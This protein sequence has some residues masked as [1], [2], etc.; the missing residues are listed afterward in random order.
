MKSDAVRLTDLAHGGGCG[1]KIA[2]S[3]L[4]EMLAKLPRQF[5]DPALIVGLESGD[6]AAV[7]QI[8]DQQAVV[9]T[10][11]FFMPIVDDPFEFG[12]IAANNALSDVYA[13]GG[14]P[15][16]ALAI[17]GMPVNK[18][19][20]ETIQEILA[21]GATVCEAAGVSLAGGH[22]IDTPEPIYGLAAIGLVSPIAVKRNDEARAND[23]LILGKALGVGIM[24]A[25]L[26]KGEL[27]SPGYKEML[28]VTTQLNSIGPDLAALPGVHALTDV[29]GFGLLGHL[30]EVCR[31]SGLGAT[32]DAARV[33]LV[34]VARDLAQAGHNSGAAGRNWAS[35]GDDVVLPGDFPE[36]HHNL[37]CDPQ[38]SGGLLV[39]CD[40]A[41]ADQ[42]LE[43][44]HRQGYGDAAVIGEMSDGPSKVQVTA[45]AD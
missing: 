20:I 25:A 12:R 26:K 39:S 29:T 21:G 13:T 27:S 42:V 34:P 19:P 2:P 35:Y 7:Y 43:L 6:D 9:A 15:V 36:W 11:D 8:S 23:I 41:A 44:F 4:S 10:T 14:R 1:C 18:M 32:V 24:A 31:G 17:V 45:P 28:R 16:L 22:S 30:M 5:A 37:L 3:V 40:P 33:P 38:T